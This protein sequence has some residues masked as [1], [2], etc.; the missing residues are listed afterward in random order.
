[1]ITGNIQPRTYK[2]RKKNFTLK[3]FCDFDGTVT[4]NDVWIASMG[5]FIKDREKFDIVCRD[6]LNN[7]ITARECNRRE[8]DLVEDFSFEKLNKYLDEEQLD[9][10]FREFIGFCSENG[11]EITLLSEGLDYYI[12][13]ILKKENINLKFFS[14]KLVVNRHINKESNKITLKLTCEFP[15]SDEN[16]TYCGMSKRNVLINGTDDFENE[17]SVYIGDGVSDCCAVNYA[18]IVFAKKHLASYCWK[19]NITYFDFKN[20]LDVKNKLIKLK[21]Q[22]KIRPRQTAKILRRDVLL[23]G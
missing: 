6:F 15:H 21:A 19:N 11:Y 9:D 20:F 2:S 5:R 22:N 17:V 14:N 18:D 13:Y 4:K 23:G 12:N 1:L 3:I 16:C 10:Y 7:A 8:L